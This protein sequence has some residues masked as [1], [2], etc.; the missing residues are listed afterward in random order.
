MIYPI[1]SILKSGENRAKV[2]PELQTLGY[3]LLANT[4]L[5]AEHYVHAPELNL[6]RDRQ[7]TG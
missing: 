3:A 2:R 4:E 6:S 7:G 5:R 1:V